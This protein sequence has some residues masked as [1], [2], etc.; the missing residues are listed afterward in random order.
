MSTIPCG[1]VRLKVSEEQQLPRF[2]KRFQFCAH[3]VEGEAVAGG[4]QSYVDVQMTGLA[5][6]RTAGP[7]L[8]GASKN[9]NNAR[10]VL[11]APTVDESLLMNNVFARYFIYVGGALLA[12]LLIANS[13]LAELP[14]AKSGADHPLIRV[15][16]ERKWPD[17][18][19]YDTNQVMPAPPVTPQAQIPP[20]A[21]ATADITSANTREAFAQ[22]RPSEAGKPPDKKKPQRKAA[23]R[24]TPPPEFVVPS[25]PQFAWF[26]PRYRW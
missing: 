4:M 19:V 8:R 18:I 15:H 7:K 12:M 26:G 10:D 11:H 23:R 25:Q 14:V 1:S 16:S 20:P 22:L 6:A 24:R 5:N 17:R 13:Y 3:S 21:P 2:G 9:R